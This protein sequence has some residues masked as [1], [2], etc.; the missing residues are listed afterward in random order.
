M[1]NTRPNPKAVEFA[2]RNWLTSQLLVRGFEV[3]IPVVDRGVD[4]IVFK[5]IGSA[6]IRAL[7]LQLK[8]SL[9]E[10]F[11]VD[12]K[13]EGRGIPLCYI[14]NVL[15]TPTALLMNYDEALDSLPESARK[16]ASWA[17]NGYYTITNNPSADLRSKLM[18]FA[19][20]WN[21]LSELLESQPQ[22]TS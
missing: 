18:E 5:E 6:G 1:S 19:D 9:Y 13:Y 17:Q 16:S 15:G 14:W 20:R 3:S 2:G 22:S 21:W 4:L 12:R 8:C 11:S 10:S 7:P